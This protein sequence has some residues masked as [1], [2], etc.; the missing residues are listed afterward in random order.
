LDISLPEFFV[1]DTR[2][3]NTGIQKRIE[4]AMATM[5]ADALNE[6]ETIVEGIIALY[7]RQ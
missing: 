6:L 5:P 3:C 1:F 4:T 2:Q 7:R